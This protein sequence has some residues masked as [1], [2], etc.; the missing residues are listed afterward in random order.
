MAARARDVGGSC[1]VNRRPSHGTIVD[2]RL[3]LP[4]H[5]VRQ[6]DQGI[7]ASTRPETT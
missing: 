6:P 1:T 5:L 2:A 7:H 4:A 3:P